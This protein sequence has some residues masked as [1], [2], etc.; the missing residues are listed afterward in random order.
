[1]LA[2]PAAN[3]DVFIRLCSA[4]GTERAVIVVGA[5]GVGHCERFGLAV[6]V[7]AGLDHVDRH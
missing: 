5:V 1:M 6:S 2:A 4:A 3:Q 7:T